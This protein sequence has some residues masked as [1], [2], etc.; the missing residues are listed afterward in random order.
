MNRGTEDLVIGLTRRVKAPNM[1]AGQVEYETDQV[2]HHVRIH[3]ESL[4]RK[5]GHKLRSRYD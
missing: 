4:V 2:R 3:V 1:I 5:H